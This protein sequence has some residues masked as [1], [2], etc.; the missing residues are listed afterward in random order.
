MMQIIIQKF[1]KIN[2]YENKKRN[3]SILQNINEIIK[4]HDKFIQDL[5][6]IIDQNNINNKFIDMIN[7]YNKMVLEISVKQ[8]NE[9]KNTITTLA[10]PNKKVNDD[11]ELLIKKEGKDFE[12]FDIKNLKKVI[13]FKTNFKYDRFGTLELKDGRIL[14]YHSDS[15]KDKNL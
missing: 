3:Y 15:D 9:S 5:N 10:K 13:S 11:I 6:K 14:Y 8:E 7:L 12:N 4:Y 2:S 1:L